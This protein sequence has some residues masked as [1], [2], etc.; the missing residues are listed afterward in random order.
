VSLAGGDP[1]ALARA[2]RRLALKWLALG[3]VGG[4]T[5]VAAWFGTTLRRAPDV[6]SAPR[7]QLVAASEVRAGTANAPAPLAPAADAPPLASVAPSVAGAPPRTAGS[8]S[9]PHARRDAPEAAQGS[10]GQ[11]RASRES[12]L[13]AEVA[14]LDSVRSKLELGDPDGA[15]QLIERYELR[16]PNGQLAKDAEVLALEALAGTADRAQL[17]RRAD[18]FLLRS[19]DDPHAARVRQL[20][21]PR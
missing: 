10:A 9:S 15:L 8:R 3:A 16:F 19:P 21:S 14:L 20:L 4:G 18:R 13:L 5:L 17:T 6:A 1:V 7:P 12:T 2:S 11:D